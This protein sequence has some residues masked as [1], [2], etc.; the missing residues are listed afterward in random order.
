MVYNNLFNIIF[1]LNY[2]NG[3][4]YNK[5]TKSMFHVKHTDCINISTQYNVSRETK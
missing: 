2:M 4:Y 5:L 3:N 1:C